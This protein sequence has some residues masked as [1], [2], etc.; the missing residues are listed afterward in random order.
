MFD[1]TILKNISSLFSIQLASYIIPLFTLPYLVRTLGVESFG[2]MGFS[3]A[4]IQYCTLIINY[5]FNLSATSAI[6]KIRDDKIKVSDIFS[7]VLVIRLLAFI[8]SAVFLFFGL[9]IFDVSE[10]VSKIL[11]A[12]MGIP[13]GAALFPQFLFQGKEQLGLISFAR[14]LVQLL[15]IPLLFIFV[16]SS[17]DVWIAV[18]ISSLSSLLLAI[19][20]L[21][22]IYKRSWVLFKI[23]NINVLKQQLTDGWHIFV[24][25]VAISLY[26]SSVTV[27]LG[28]FAGPVSVGYF[29]AA[30]KIIKAVLGLYGV[31]SNAFYPR[32]NS[33]VEKSKEDAIKLLRKLGMLLIL[34]AVLCNFF[35]FILADY[36]IFMLF[37]TGHETTSKLLKILSFLPVIIAFSNLLGIQILIPFGYKKEFSKV[38]LV[39]G[40]ISLLILIPSVF[41]Y[42]EYGAAISVL[43]IEIFVTVLMA[44]K[45]MKLKIFKVKYEV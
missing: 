19:Y 28:V 9:I 39:S 32:V 8:L 24:S 6:S 29:V 7:G 34:I 36:A 13:L 23:P 42:A 25:T 10:N 43:F 21:L 18:L 2:Y 27:I 41:F 45:V 35:T 4:I 3:L 12:A 16:N 11:A 33:I 26:T 5:G 20:S 37:G 30:D 1:K 22:L 31:I 17:N 15:T 40:V 44:H 38:L 14:V